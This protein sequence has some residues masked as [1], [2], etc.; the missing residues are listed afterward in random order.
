MICPNC[1]V[2]ELTGKKQY[3]SDKCRMA[4]T[5]RTR[6]GETEQILPTKPNKTY[7]NTPTRTDRLFE[8]LNPSYY[9]YDKTEYEKVCVSCSKGFSTH[10]QLMKFCSPKCKDEAFKQINKLMKEKGL[11]EIT[12]GT[13]KVEF[14][15]SGIEEIDKLTGGFP[16]KRITEIFG[17]KGVGKTQ[18]MS[19]ILK[20]S[21][22]DVSIYYVDTE[23][24]LEIDGID[25]LNE[26]I[27]ERVEEAVEVAMQSNYDLIIVDS[28]ASMIPWA[29][30]EG[31]AGDAHMG[32]KARLMGQWMR[33]IN[34]HLSKSN[35][36][37][38]FINQQ[39]ETMN[40]Y[41]AKKFTPGGFA[42]PYAASLRIELKS[43]KADKKENHQLVTAIVEKSRFSK[44]YQKAEFKLRYE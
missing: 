13:P 25:T 26:N 12:R 32:L 1:E 30:M 44:P 35:T 18:L 42:L 34:F 6:Q 23:N 20:Q 19:R 11:P 15:S 29:E 4:F 17:L 40:P 14:I 2:K 31:E 5:R 41:G 39:R 7:P 28:V 9:N 3:C 21:L 27:L 43:N 24:A 33:K 37:L 38:V 10:L 36:A 16:R 8:E 22:P